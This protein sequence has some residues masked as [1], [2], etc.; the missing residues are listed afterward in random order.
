[1]SNGE[2]F[3]DSTTTGYMQLGYALPAANGSYIKALQQ[4]DK[5][6]IPATVGGSSSTFVA[7]GLWT[8]TGWLVSLVGGG[9]NNG[10]LA[11]L[12]AWTGNVSSAG[13][14]RGR[15]ARLTFRKT[16]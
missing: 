8:A 2:T 5:G 15:G 12:C 4:L 14:Y 13:R 1:V 6:L 7:D 3:T 16:A 10:G 11:G 9:A